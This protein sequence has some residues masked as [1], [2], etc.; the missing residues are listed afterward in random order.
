MSRKYLFYV[1]IRTCVNHDQSTPALYTNVSVFTSLQSIR[2]P[3]FYVQFYTGS[4][5][6]HLKCYQYIWNQ[7]PCCTLSFFDCK[8]D[9][10]FREEGFHWTYK[11][12]WNWYQL[13]MGGFHK[14][15][16]APAY[17]NA[18]KLKCILYYLKMECLE[19]ILLILCYYI[20]LRFTFE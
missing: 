10:K 8:A 9:A 1:R 6:Y 11:C 16:T 14:Y 15:F 18:Y 3:V 12:I 7:N 13:S 5:A 19:L 20:V 17:Y 4:V 2:F